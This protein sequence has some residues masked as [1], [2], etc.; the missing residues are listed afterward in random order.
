MQATKWLG[1]E[2]VEVTFKEKLISAVGAALAIYC[3]FWFT[4]SFLPSR[5]AIG[6]VASMGATA[7]LL[8]AVPHG[9]LSQPWPLVGGH[10]VSALIGVSCVR[11]ISNPALA[12]ALAVGASIG[13][14]HQLKCI[15]PPGGATAFTAV[16]G[17]QAIGDLGYMY[18]LYPVALNAVIMLALA[19][20]IN[21]PFCWRRYPA[22]LIKR[23]P[24]Q[25]AA[26]VLVSEHDHRNIVEAVR[27]L[28]SFVDVSE[29]DILYLAR[30][31]A[32]H[33]AQRHSTSAGEGD[34]DYAV[35]T[36][37]SISP[38]TIPSAN[39]STKP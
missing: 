22:V 39:A 1:V 7:V 11:I 12:T 16:M 13:V 26:I 6:V 36:P 3:V 9:Q 35:R 31:M 8:F 5:A 10:I 18:V 23:K 21:F 15:H 37:K 27:S 4:H 17:G 28:D 34:L 38:W 29:E 33:Y 2:L 32:A 24:A 14:M 19:V 30:I 25:D 20:L